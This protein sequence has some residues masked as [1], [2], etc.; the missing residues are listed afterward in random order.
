M[1]EPQTEA[2]RTAKRIAMK[3]LRKQARQSGS[4]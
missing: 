1:P 3:A 4:F 2:P